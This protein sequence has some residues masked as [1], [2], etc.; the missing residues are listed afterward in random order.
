MLLYTR[1]AFQQTFQQTSTSGLGGIVHCYHHKHGFAL[2]PRPLQLEQKLQKGFF[3][4]F[5][6]NS[7]N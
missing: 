2:Y 4:F 3:K 7:I 6:V 5:F 1:Y